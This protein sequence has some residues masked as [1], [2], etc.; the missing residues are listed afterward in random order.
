MGKKKKE[1]LN[2]KE[3]REQVKASK[4][5]QVT[6]FTIVAVV[7]VAIIIL[8]VV[9]I[10]AREATEE[11]APIFCYKSRVGNAAISIIAHRNGYLEDEGFDVKVFPSG[12]VC[13]EALL[14][15]DADF[16]E[17]GDAAFLAMAAQHPYIWVCAHAGGEDRDRIIVRDDAGIDNISDLE[18]KKIAIKFG[19]SCMCGMKR[20][21]DAN[22]LD[23]VENE[24]LVNV[25]PADM[26]TALSTGEVDAICFS[27][28]TPSKA[29]ATVDCHELCTIGG[30]GCNFP[31]GIA[32]K[33]EYAKD[34]PEIVEAM[35]RALIKA[36]QFIESDLEGAIQVQADATEE[37]PDV[38]RN[39][40]SYHFY[41]VDIT[42]ESVDTLVIV[43]DYL[44]DAGDIDSVPAMSDVVDNTYLK[45]VGRGS[46]S[47]GGTRDG[48]TGSEEGNSFASESMVLAV[49]PVAL[50]IPAGMMFRRKKCI[51]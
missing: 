39:A 32:V 20:F 4:A 30:Y 38:I 9:L 14:Y 41:D 3:E 48:A 45:S 1:E 8:A 7:I 43:G 15:G 33:K 51:C 21:A 10:V 40:M 23:L 13:V 42:K 24:E 28:P 37:D 29:E 31:M 46:Y 11:K 19:T 50:L 36:E 18:G 16:G 5:K 2:E 25:K 17:M 35:L 44:K 47:I 6:I 26:V 27:E 22:G 12:P 49:A 34:N